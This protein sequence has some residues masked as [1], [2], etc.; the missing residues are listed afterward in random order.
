MFSVFKSWYIVACLV[1]Q[2]RKEGNYPH[3]N[4]ALQTTGEQVGV[5]AFIY[6]SPL[7]AQYKNINSHISSTSIW[8]K[9]WTFAMCLLFLICYASCIVRDITWLKL[10][11]KWF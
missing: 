10:N 9:R 2:N 11:S 6:I 5:W 3:S 4:I 8:K 1:A 7:S